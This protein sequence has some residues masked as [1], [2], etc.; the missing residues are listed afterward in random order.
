MRK[1]VLCFVVLCLCFSSPSLASPPVTA[2]LALELDASSLTG[3]NNGDVVSVWPDSSGRGNA[4]ISTGT[5]TYIASDSTINNM[6]AIRITGPRD[7][8]GNPTGESGDWYALQDEV[9]NVQTVAMVF[10]RTMDRAL[11]EMPSIL[12]SSFKND[13]SPYDGSQWRQSESAPVGYE[14]YDHV[15]WGYWYTSPSVV[16]G[17]QQVTHNDGVA[18]NGYGTWTTVDSQYQIMT[19]QIA[20]VYGDE[21]TYPA[22]GGPTSV[23]LIGHTNSPGGD[24]SGYIDPANTYG[25]DIAE[26]L[27]YDQ[28]LTAGELGDVTNYL[29]SK[30]S[31][32]EP[33]TIMFL[34]LGIG[35]ILRRSKK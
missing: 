2:N 18:T 20:I 26:L 29:M 9:T 16:W 17:A 11:P 24:I 6:P 4:A 5:P 34:G 3:Y 27:I 30:Y 15:Y 22:Y 8:L 32:P 31:V 13:G 10:K 21:Q 7:L 12:E 28:Q 23:G 33:A 35:A 25:M 1:F 14:Y 19:L